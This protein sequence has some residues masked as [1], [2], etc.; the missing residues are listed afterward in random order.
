MLYHAYQMMT[1][2]AEPVRRFARL[3]HA[4]FAVPDGTLGPFAPRQ[5]AAFWSMI[6][7]TAYTHERPAYAIDSVRVGNVDAAVTEQAVFSTPFGT[8]LHFA[9]DVET[10]QPK[11]LVVAPL[12]GHFATLL[13][14][15][16][17]TLLADHDVYITDWH[18]ARDVPLG[19]G[20][21]GFD[22]YVE[23]VIRFIEEIG[24][25]THVLAVCQPCVQVLAAAAVMAEDRNPAAPSSMTLMAGPVDVRVN[26]TEVNRLANGKPLEW[27]AEKLIATVPARYG[28]AGRRVYPGF[29]QLTAFMMMNPA[30]HEKAHR[31]LHRHLARGETAE[32]ATIRAFYDEYFAVLDLDAEFYLETIDIVFQRALLAKGELSYRGRPVDPAKIR[33]TALLTVEGERDDICA[34]GQTAAAHDLCTGLKPFLKRHHM[35]PGVGHYGVFSGRRWEGQVYPIVRNMVLATS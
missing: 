2:A 21:F 9:K 30:R 10:P 14:G 16:V 31:D 15:T 7:D 5:A 35:Q 22:D 29:L 13:R 24:P 20:R 1:D 26:P 28:G 27:F 34:L 18:N 12:S 6:A 32:A 8:L 25:G 33:R 23:H 4:M 17:K 3:A 11:M 19:A